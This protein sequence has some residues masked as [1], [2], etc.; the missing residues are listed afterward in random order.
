VILDP[1]F[2][3]ALAVWSALVASVSFLKGC[4]YAETKAKGEYAKALEAAV[5]EERKG[6]VIDM[7]AAAEVEAERAKARVIY[8]DRIVTVKEYL[9][10]NPPARECVIAKP[11]VEL[12]NDGSRCANNPA[13]CPKPKPMPDAPPARFRDAGG[14]SS[15]VWG[16]DW[17]VW[18]V[19]GTS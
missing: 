4:D 5:E 10:A 14:I 18:R 6:A 9:N 8:K 16:S 7:M 13:A 3:L 19:R 15:D 1:R 17:T 2:W 12:L 11:I